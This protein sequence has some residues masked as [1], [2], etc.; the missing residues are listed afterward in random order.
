MSLDQLRGVQER[1]DSPSHSPERKGK[2]ATYRKSVFP[3]NQL[4]TLENDEPPVPQ[5]DG[6]QSGSNADMDIGHVSEYNEEV[7][8]AEEY[9]SFSTLSDPLSLASGGGDSEPKTPPED[10]SF[11]ENMLQENPDQCAPFI[12][13][14]LGDSQFLMSCVDMFSEDDLKL[15]GDLLWN[16]D[17]EILDMENEGDMKK[18]LS[19]PKFFPDQEE[20]SPVLNSKEIEMSTPVLN[21]PLLQG[22]EMWFEM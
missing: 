14:P 8:E 9:S 3:L 17:W 10:C 1:Q 11:Y 13:P 20:G 15:D 5:I 2:D 16:T 4:D 18:N 12:P 7:N 22:N 21:L 19:T 6:G